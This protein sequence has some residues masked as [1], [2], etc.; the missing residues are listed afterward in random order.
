LQRKKNV[1]LA[2]WSSLIACKQEKKVGRNE[3]SFFFL[4]F[5]LWMEL[6]MTIFLLWLCI[7]V[8]CTVTPWLTHRIPCCSLYCG[9]QPK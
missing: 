8:V 6:V 2:F 1:F 7:V 4:F 9:K 3:W 5:L